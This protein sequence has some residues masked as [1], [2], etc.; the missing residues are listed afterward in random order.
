MADITAPSTTEKATNDGFMV[1]RFRD[2]TQ[3]VTR[4]VNFLNTVEGTGSPDGVLESNANKFY[5]DTAAAQLYWKS[6]DD[7]A[8]DKSLGWKL[9]V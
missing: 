4:L 8:G 1:Q 3:F 5:R 2:W 6:V 9:I 7:I